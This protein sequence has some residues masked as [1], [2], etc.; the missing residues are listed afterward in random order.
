[1]PEGLPV[2][3]VINN[4]NDD[5]FESLYPRRPTRQEDCCDRGLVRRPA[6]VV[7]GHS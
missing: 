2:R 5:G 3:D 1:M 4:F 6:A 7:G